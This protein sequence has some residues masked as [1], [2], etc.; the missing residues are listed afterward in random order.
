MPW[1]IVTLGINDKLPLES[2]EILLFELYG[3]IS[4]CLAFSYYP[5]SDVPQ[6]KR[7]H[8]IFL[9]VSNCFQRL[10]FKRNSE[11]DFGF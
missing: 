2:S 4:G 7:H 3:K 10:A 5:S 6:S 11:M 8:F 1:I 9:W